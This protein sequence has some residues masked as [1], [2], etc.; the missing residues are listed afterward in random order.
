[1]GMRIPSRPAWLLVLALAAPA[2]HAGLFDD[3]EARKANLDQRQKIELLNQQL[4]EQKA[5][6][7]DNAA[8]LAAQ[9][10]ASNEQLGQLRR[11]LL[12]LNNQLEAL[13]GELARMRGS[14]EQL[15]RDVAEV[16]RRQKDIQQGVDDRIRKLEP[17]KVSV[18]DQE[19]LADPEEKRQFEE[20]MALFRKSDFER[21]AP[22]F[23]GFTKRYPGSG[24]V[25]SAQFWLG[26]AQY[27][28]RE[29]KEAILS[30][31]GL[32]NSAADHPKA[33]EALLSIA[34]CQ[35]EL[36]DAKAARRTIDELIK[37]YPKSEAAAAGKER[38]AG[39]K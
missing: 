25:P 33:P 38:L 4:G 3:D 16:Q 21:A 29:Y 6:Q 23:A 5:R 15:A 27:A 24:Y 20:A 31:R 19:F 12:D 28:K 26:N 9:Q 34:N 36:K 11:S 22:L 14:E 17:V 10:A 1:M 30:F 7:A 13:R 32:V 2:A 8:A 37:T 18:D 35:F 39:L